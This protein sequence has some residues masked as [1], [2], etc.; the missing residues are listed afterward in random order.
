MSTFSTARAVIGTVGCIAALGL[1]ILPADAA[2]K[3]KPRKY[4]FDDLVTPSMMEPPVA[5]IRTPSAAGAR[6]FSIN[7]VLAKLDGKSVPNEPVRLASAASD[8]IVS[9]APSEFTRSEAS[10]SSPN[11]PFGLFT[12]R[13]PEGIL[14]RKWRNV[15]KDIDKEMSEIANCKADSSACSGAARRFLLMVDGAL[16]HDGAAR[17]ETVNRLVNT[18]IRY[19]SDL[20]QHGEVDL[21]SSPL[22]SL[23]AGRGDCEDY[24]IAKYMVLRES[25]VPEQDLRILLVRDRAVR[26]DHAV[27]AVRKDGGWTILDNRRATLFGDSDLP[28]FSPLVALDS[29]GVSLFASPYLSQRMNSDA[30]AVA[31]A[32][33]D[34]WGLALPGEAIVQD[35]AISLDLSDM[36][37]SGGISGAANLPL[38][39]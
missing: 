7:S 17:L 2:S 29:G 32:S 6:F 37:S 19:T 30:K 34:P 39:L 21:W 18:A 26:E 33:A 14:W 35:T 10:Q 15:K 16:E 31:P 9:D 4:I 3:A 38:L 8:T 22:A 24:A 13:A 36:S 23:R 25:G 28:Q 1:S 12:F 11:E 27:L 20:I 5:P